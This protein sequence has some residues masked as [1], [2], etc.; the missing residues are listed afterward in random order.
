VPASDM[1]TPM[2]DR[3]PTPAPADRVGNVR[4]DPSDGAGG[5]RSAARIARRELRAGTRGFRIFLACLAVGVA[6]ITAIQST[7]LSLQDSLRADG[8]TILG[9]DLSL[10]RIYQPATD[11]EMQ[12]LTD[13]GRVSTV[14]QLRAM[15]RTADGSASALVEL[16]AVDDAYPLVGEA[17]LT[18][19]QSLDQA[20]H[21]ESAPAGAVV[22]PELMQRL[23]LKP[24]DTLLIGEARFP[25]RATLDREPDRIGTGIGFGPRVIIPLSALEDTGLVRPGSIVHWLYRI[26]LFDGVD[27]ESWKATFQDRFS[28]AGWRVRDFRAA[29]PQLTR[30][31]DRLT[32][33]LTLVGLTAL[34]VGGVGVGNAVNAYLHGKVY[35]IATLKCVG[36]PGALILRAY[37]LQILALAAIGISI[38]LIIGAAAPF[39]AADAV[40]RLAGLTFAPALYPQSLAVAVA[41]GLLTALVFSLWPLGKAQRVPPVALF[42]SETTPLVVRPGPWISGAVATAALALAAVAVLS[43][44][45]QLFAAWYIA[46]AAA[47]F[48]VLA[49]LAAALRAGIKRLPRVSSPAL[50][51]ALANLHRPGN[52]TL[53][54]LMSLGLGLTVLVAIA[55]IERN[56]DAQVRT[57]LPEQ[58]P[59]FFLI[60]IQ[61]DQLEPL[62]RLATDMSGIADFDSV[63]ALRG[64]IVTVND[65]PA[66]RAVVD[67]EH[68]WVLRG[69]RG[70]TYAATIPEN[71]T[72]IRGAWWPEDYRGPPLVSVYKD[73][74]DAF[75]IGPGDRIGVN[76]LGRTIEAEIASVREINFLSMS[77][78]FTMVFSPGL[79]EGAPKTH[80][81]TVDAAPD[82]ETAFQ[83]AVLDAYPNVSAIRVRDALDA[84]TGVIEKIGLA[85]RVMAAVAVFVGVLVLAGAVAAGHQQRLYEAVVLKVLGA[86]RADVLRAYALEFLILGL[87]AGLAAAA[88][89]LLTAWAVLTQI[90]GWPWT[91]FP[92]TLLA[93]LGLSLV[94]TVTAGLAGTWRTLTQPA[95]P[96]LRNE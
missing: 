53:G 44:A 7:A 86:T 38:G 16:K 19:A 79:L 32:V 94:I 82:R 20:L 65:Q 4:S 14:A 63:P 78:N 41:F 68:A 72:V 6:A 46:G 22:A 89:G 45:N 87:L 93:V 12:V 90:M 13:A 17:G 54:V 52:R 42:R 96:M 1:T 40:S 48:V 83:K 66:E 2:Q 67:P 71:S 36:A 69:D 85:V 24:G 60:D 62:R 58:A 92:G 39:L 23:N 35:T 26:S 81:A 18:P 51:L 31:I 75:G 11:A 33:F 25:V 59:A 57:T 70:V 30:F 27:V 34:L 10:R 61:P 84:V 3:E 64:R 8:Q 77:L 15:A 95:A 74:A 47:T 43:A 21:P 50:R 37:L 91:P 88:I 73:I 55:L 9:G 56:F 49:L 5:W 76:I 80:I 28:E 29:S